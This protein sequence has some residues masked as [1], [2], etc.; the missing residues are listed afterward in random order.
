MQK[1]KTN[2]VDK[3]ES[4]LK[5]LKSFGSVYYN[6]GVIEAILTV[7]AIR[8]AQEKF[9]HRPVNGEEA[10]W[11]LE[12]L[13][14]DDAR[15]RQIGAEGLVQPTVLSITD[16]EGGGAGKILQWDGAAFHEVSN[17]WIKSDRDDLL[18]VI[19][20]RAAA[21]AKEHGIKMRSETETR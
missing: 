10:N 6:S 5:D 19:Y 1:I 13:K 7:D 4:D 9:G 3:G 14:L 8:K 11:G 12:H 15:L 21:Y 2:I 17:G 18:P 20:E 16:H